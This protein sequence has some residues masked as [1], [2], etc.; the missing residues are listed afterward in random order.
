MRSQMLK[1][2]FERYVNGEA[3]PA[4]IRQIQSWLS[5]TSRDIYISPREKQ[6]LERKIMRQ[7]R[8]KAGLSMMSKIKSYLS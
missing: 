3:D 6:R 8:S 5:C 2:K 4:E 7:I 1:N